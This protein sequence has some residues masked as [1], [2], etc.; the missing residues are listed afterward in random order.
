MKTHKPLNICLFC[1]GSE[2]DGNTL[3][4][5]S[6]GGSETAGI[7]I[8]EA[9]SDLG[10]NV[11]VF[12]ECNGLNTN[13][14]VY[15]GVKY[16]SHL[17]F[18]EDTQ[19]NNYDVVIVSRRHNLL[20]YPF[21]SKVNILWNQ[22]Y[23]WMDH[24][25][26]LYEALWNIDSIFTLTDFHKNQQKDTWN[27]PEDAFWVAGNGIDLDLINS[28]DAEERDPK[29]LIYA[30]R[31][32]RGLD[33]LLL[34]T[35]PR[36]LNHDPDLKLYITT[37]DFF[38]ENIKQYIERL[39]EATI[40]I[41]DSIVWLPPL[42][43]EDLYKH[44]KT[45][46]LYLY[47]SNYKE[48]YC[49]V[50]AESM[51]CGTPVVG[52]SIGALPDIM[53]PEASILLTGHREAKSDVYQEEFVGRTLELLSNKELLN[54]FSTA[55]KEHAKT[56]DWKVNA[57]RWDG[58]FR[59]LLKN[60]RGKKSENKKQTLSVI[61]TTKNNEDTISQTLASVKGIADEIIVDDYGSTD[62]TL[63]ILKTYNCTILD[64][65]ILPLEKEGYEASR[66]RCKAACKSDWVLWLH[67]D[68]QLKGDISKYL[69][70]NIYEGYSF[71]H[72]ILDNLVTKD[73][74]FDSPA[75]LFRN[76]KEFS[77]YGLIHERLGL[78]RN[79]FNIGKIG[80][81]KDVLLLNT[82]TK[83]N[84]QEYFKTIFPLVE[85]DKQKYLN[86]KISSFYLMHNLLLLCKQCIKTNQQKNLINW[87]NAIEAEYDQCFSGEISRLS[88]NALKIAS[89]VNTL[90]NR[91]ICLDQLNEQLGKIR[92]KNVATA[93]KFI[94]LYITDSTKD[95]DSEYY[96][97]KAN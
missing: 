2:F 88:L 9:L 59:E 44:L 3:N 37:Y 92:F 50:A 63:E 69:K 76:K 81:I 77:F 29:K 66:N 34:Q 75:K 96:L 19:K 6:L 93:K 46:S 42:K 48:G 58:K 12:S 31:P 60:S 90:L 53:P 45:S 5:K 72:Q 11:T 38:P 74:Y 80:H 30:S 23:A 73:F 39:K 4:H 1:D 24:K 64:S 91:G 27:L 82:S 47:P 41:K 22:D 40:S 87:C 52:S 51:A 62:N 20:K 15:N 95:L 14:G 36:L 21:K 70:T 83:E 86:R 17:T 68:E 54:K 8:A 57:K 84:I 10:N 49:I 61:I 18:I 79:N 32:E 43:K 35:F 94:A 97:P 28:I 7:Q 56:L 89:D 71:S 55:A 78:N 13:P 33:I 16:L 26:E 67:P 85:A 65:H 25:Q